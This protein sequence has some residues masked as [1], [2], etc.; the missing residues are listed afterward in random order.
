MLRK[1]VMLFAML[2]GLVVVA[3]PASAVTID[4]DL[5]T[6]R[7]HVTSNS[8]SYDWAI[9]SARSGFRTPHGY[10][11]P[12]SLQVMHYSHKYHMSPMPHSIFFLGGYAIHGTYSTAQLGHPASHGCVRLAP[13]NAAALFAMVKSEGARISI[14]GTPPG[15]NSYVA[16][17]HHH[18][19]A[20]TMLASHHHGHTTH[21]LAYAPH[22]HHKTLHQWMHNPGAAN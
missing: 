17:N 6:Q 2:C 1:F 19:K 7:M 21:A 3:R 18:K 14:S 15:G 13:A 10:F 4:I 5:S 8:G 16:H 11:H 22:R 9:S 12:T 20:A